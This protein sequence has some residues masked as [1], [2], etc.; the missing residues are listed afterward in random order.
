M[1]IGAPDA[2]SVEIKQLVME[3]NQN[4]VGAK[5]R[6]GNTAQNQCAAVSPIR[7]IQVTRQMGHQMCSVT[8]NHNKMCP[9]SQDQ[10]RM[11]PDSHLTIATLKVMEGEEMEEVQMN[12]H[13]Y[14]WNS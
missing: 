8:Q 11:D 14:S 6:S 2:R 10:N 9:V 13:K 7:N 5:L 1:T 12:Q 4:K 3:P